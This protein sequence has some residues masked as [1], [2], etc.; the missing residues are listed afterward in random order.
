MSDEL[1]KDDAT[2]QDDAAYKDEQEHNTRRR[3]LTA[4]LTFL[5][6][7]G[8]VITSWPFIASMSPSTRAQAAGA[9]VEVDLKKIESGKML[10]EKWRDTPIWIVKRTPAMIESLNITQDVVRDPDSDKSVQPEY[11]K[12]EYR[13]IKPE[14]LVLVGIC[15]HLGCS[16]SYRPQ[17]GAKD[18][19]SENWHGGF[20][21][22]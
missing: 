3:F 19:M 16:P 15:T 20:C 7:V 6:G 9:P 10:R 18:G 5:G 12:N 14:Y 4:A 13:S 1:N 11:A 2:H 22:S 17:A 8:G 21:C